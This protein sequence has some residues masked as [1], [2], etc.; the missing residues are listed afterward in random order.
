M[1]MRK[2][3][4]ALAV[5]GGVLGSCGVGMADTDEI[6][7]E[8][9]E[10]RAVVSL[11]NAARLVRFTDLKDGRELVDGKVGACRE[12]F[13]ANQYP[14]MLGKVC[15]RIERADKTEAVLSGEFRDAKR[16]YDFSLRKTLRLDGKTLHVAFALTNNGKEVPFS[17]RMSLMVAVSPA[18]T[19]NA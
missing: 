14:G 5:C 12:I 1:N 19:N 18:S 9:A 6:V 15:Y 4:A 10:V 7:L 11:K 13:P 8:N 16:G 3:I 2:M 17:L